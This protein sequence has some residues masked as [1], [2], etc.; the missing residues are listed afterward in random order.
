M[1][2]IVLLFAIMVLSLNASDSKNLK[3]MG[4]AKEVVLSTQKVRGGTYNF[5]NGSEFAQFGVYEERARLKKLFKSLDI[6]FEG[7]GKT[8]TQ[9]FSKLKKQVHSLNVLSFELEPAT[10]FSAYSLLVNKMLEGTKSMQVEF[11]SSSNEYVKATTNMMVSN[12]LVLS[13]SIGKVRGLG[14][15]IISRSKFEDDE[16]DL[17]RE[18]VDELNSNYSDAIRELEKIYDEHG[19]KYPK[20]YKAKIDKLNTSVIAYTGFVQSNI[21]SASTINEDPNR[22]FKQGTMIINQIMDLYTQNEDIVRK[23]F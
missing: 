4:T 15:G 11:F 18:Y 13:E 22:Y 9:N 10:S 1:K 14:S 17:L 20:G 23:S 5:L 2:K 3:Y 12:L 6:P 7:G 8:I 19:D 16:K 21:L